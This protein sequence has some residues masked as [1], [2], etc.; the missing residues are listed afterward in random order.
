[1]DITEDTNKTQAQL[2]KWVIITGCEIKNEI[3]KSSVLL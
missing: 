2:V 3:W 1:M